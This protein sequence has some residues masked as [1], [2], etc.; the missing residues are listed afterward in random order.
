MVS[1]YDH[2]VKIGTTTKGLNLVRD[3]KGAA[4]YK[5]TEEVPGFDAQIKFAMNNWAGGHGQYFMKQPDLWFDGQSID[6]TIDNK[7]IL[8][9]LINQVG[10]AAGALD[11]NPV[12][13]C[14]F[15]AI[16]KLMMATTEHVY[17]YD[18]TNWVSKKDF[19]AGH[20]ITDMKEYNGTLF[21]ALGSAHLYYFTADGVTYTET[22]TTDGYADKFFV[23]PNAAGTANVLWKSKLPNQITSNTDGRL[24]AGGEWSSPAYIGDT[25]NNITNIFTVNDNLMIGRTDNLYH[26][27]SDGGVHPLMDNLKHNRSTNNFKYV[28]DWQTSMYFSHVTGLGEITSYNSFDPMGPLSDIGDISKNGTCVGLASDK[29]FLYALIDEG[30]NTHIYKGREKRRGD[31]LRWEW[32][33]WVFLSTNNCTTALVVQ[34]SASDRRLWF[35]YGNY[36]GYVILSDNPLADTN[37]RFAASGWIRLSYI[38]GNNPLWDK[39]YQTIVTETTGCSANVTVTPKYRKDTDTAMTALTAAIT[40]NGVVHT[41]LTNALDCKRMQFELDFATNSSSITPQISYFEARGTEKPTT[42]RIYDAVYA[43]GDTPSRRTET[44]R[45]FLR[46]GRASNS[47]IRFADLRYGDKTS[48]TAGT[49][50]VWVVMLPGS[51]QEIEIIHE[52][53]RAPELGVKCQFMEIPLASATISGD[54]ATLPT[55]V[56]NC[57]VYFNGTSWTTITASGVMALLSGSAGA[58]FSMNTQNITGVGTVDGVDVSAHAA[59]ATAHGLVA[60]TDPAGAALLHVMASV[61]GATAWSVVDIFDATNPA[62]LGASASPGTAVVAAHRDHVH[63]DPVIAHNASVLS[64]TIHPDTSKCR[65]TLSTNQLDIVNNQT[66]RVELDTGTVDLGSNF[67]LATWQEGVSDA[68]SNATTIIDAN[69]TTGSGFVAGMR[70]ARVTWDAGTSEGYITSVDSSTQVTIVKTVGTAFD[71]GD[72]YIIKTNYYLCKKAGYYRIFATL[73]FT[74]TVADKRYIC[75]VRGG[76][77]SG[78]LVSFGSNFAQASLAADYLSITFVTLSNLMAVNNIIVMLAKHVADVSTVDLY[79]TSFMAVELDSGS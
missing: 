65:A 21:I 60:A 44:I 76:T 47:L 29:D 8:G 31:A 51:P 37:Y 12:C 69:P 33:P 52:K 16:D 4:M 1:T 11:A 46:D 13:F 49:D 14:W 58:A 2:E 25:S 23:S 18:G 20:T 9:P 38:Y 32:C 67:Q 57:M 73:H 34:H 6:T 72:T 54:A 40:T 15:S 39:L 5:V 45:T 70:Y 17:W 79:A 75:E 64:S 24:V 78:V 56:A 35:G 10:V 42:I 19:T 48:G 41:N 61:N 66:T 7:I 36:A 3:D 62:A 77:P 26:Y 28:V 43:I 74:S 71:V 30:T 22:T 53:G 55:G 68:G 63:L 59:S 50:F 27:D